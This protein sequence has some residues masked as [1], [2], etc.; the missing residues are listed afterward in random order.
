MKLRLVSLIDGKTLNKKSMGQSH[1]KRTI[2]WR[3]T[4]KAGF[5]RVRAAYLKNPSFYEKIADREGYKTKW[6][7]IIEGIPSWNTDSFLAATRSKV[8]QGDI[9]WD[10]QEDHILKLA[11]AAPEPAPEPEVRSEA[12]EGRLTALRALYRAARHRNDDWTMKFV[13]SLAKQLK[14]GRRFSQRQMDIL[15]QKADRYNVVLPA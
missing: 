2:N 8:E 3:K 4:W 9:L 12:V 1:F 7:A 13:Q 14:D 6:I 5:D 10:N 15:N 11:D